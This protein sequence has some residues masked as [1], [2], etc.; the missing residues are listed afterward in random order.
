MFQE[1]QNHYLSHLSVLHLYPL[2]QLSSHHL[3]N[4]LDDV[5]C[6]GRQVMINKGVPLTNQ[7]LTGSFRNH[8]QLKDHP[9]LSYHSSTYVHG[10]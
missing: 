7:P 2:H 4:A 6:V 3:L 10:F 9:L 1:P 8:P 5:A